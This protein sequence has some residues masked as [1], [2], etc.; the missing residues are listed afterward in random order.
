MS[1]EAYNDEARADRRALAVRLGNKHRNV[2]ALIEDYLEDF[3]ALGAL[4][5]E[6]RVRPAQQKGGGGMPTRYALLNEEQCYFLLTLVRNTETTV[7]MKRE[8]VSAFTEYRRMALAPPTAP[9]LPAA[10]GMD[11]L[12]QFAGNVL[13]AIQQQAHTTKEE[14]KAEIRSEITQALGDRPIGGG[15]PREIHRRVGKLAKLM[16]GQRAHFSDA[17]RRLKDRYEIIGYR[18]LTVSQ[19]DD[20]VKFL[21]LQIA[22]YRTD[23]GLF[24]GDG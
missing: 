7:P 19:F 9:A 17:W 1:V 21:D 8:L 14:V 10:V 2:L 22:S 24:R 20:A 11:F 12:Q 3:Q 16:G 15:Q 4:P 5:F 6:T 18:D 13:V 23:G